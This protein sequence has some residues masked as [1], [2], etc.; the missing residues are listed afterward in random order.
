MTNLKPLFEA[1]QASPFKVAPER[2]NELEEI[3]DSRGIRIELDDYQKDWIFEARSF[4]GVNRIAFSTR[5]LER[6]WSVCYAYTAITT[7]LQQ[8]K[9]D[10][11]SFTPTHE[12]ELAFKVLDWVAQN[13]LEDIECSWPDHLPN[14]NNTS[15]FK[16]REAADHYFLMTAGRI[17]LHEIA[18]IEQPHTTD[19]NASSEIL[20]LEE[21]DADNWADNWMLGNWKSYKDEP[22]VFIGRCMGIAFC[23][24]IVLYF[25]SK[26]P[27]P[28]KTHPNP[29]DRLINFID[30][31]MPSGKPTDKLPEHAPCAMLLVVISHLLMSEGIEAKFGNLDRSYSEVFSDVKQYFN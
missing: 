31:H 11:N 28:S 3:R 4:F 24:A 12:Y 13:R 17:L 27:T 19:V 26:N 14:P 20:I 10:F 30:K 21:L 15:A 1:F 23:H 9:G 29:I 5:S 16:Y 7:E 2:E 25:G 6:L 22:K 18:H 8:Y